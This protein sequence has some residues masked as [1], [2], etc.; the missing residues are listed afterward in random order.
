MDH[1]TPASHLP[2]IFAFGNID[3]SIA[4]A[5][6]CG[7]WI[8]YVAQRKIQA[9]PIARVAI[10]IERGEI[11]GPG[12]AWLD[13]V[14]NQPC[15]GSGLPVSEVAIFHKNRLTRGLAVFHR[16]QVKGALSTLV[17]ANGEIAPVGGPIEKPELLK[18]NEEGICLPVLIDQL[19]LSTFGG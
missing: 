13:R 6:P 11:D 16:Q 2:L 18:E 3:D 12:A 15:V 9:F 10:R 19:R 1:F 5:R 17:N 4:L 14:I 8:G 7:H